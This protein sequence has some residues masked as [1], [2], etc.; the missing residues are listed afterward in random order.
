MN[1]EGVQGAA[2]H[3]SSGSGQ[4]W[5]GKWGYPPQKIFFPPTPVAAAP[6]YQLSRWTGVGGIE[7]GGGQQEL[8]PTG[9]CNSIG[10]VAS[11]FIPLCIFGLAPNRCAS[12][13][14]PLIDKRGHYIYNIVIIVNAWR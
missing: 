14:C 8:V 11:P 1:G 3:P 7:A 9:Q 12:L 13:H 10:G 4:A 2:S 5:R 6:R